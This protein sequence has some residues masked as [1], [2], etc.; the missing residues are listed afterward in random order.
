[1]VSECFRANFILNFCWPVSMPLLQYPW[2]YTLHPWFLSCCM[3][4]CM[5]RKI[6]DYSIKVHIYIWKQKETENINVGHHFSQQFNSSNISN[7]RYKKAKKNN[8]SNISN[9]RVKDKPQIRGKD[10]S[11]GNSKGKS[12][13]KGQN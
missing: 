5:R 11:K 12:K 3:R 4:K 8:S 6:L 10:K 13:S 9:F 1:M 7:L 2:F